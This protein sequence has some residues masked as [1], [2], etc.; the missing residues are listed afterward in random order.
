[1]YKHIGSSARLRW[2]IHRPSFHGNEWFAVDNVT[3]TDFQQTLNSLFANHMFF[4][5]KSRY[6][7]ALGSCSGARS[8]R[9]LLF[10]L[11]SSYRD[12]IHPPTFSWVIFSASS[13]LSMFSATTRRNI[14]GLTGLMMYA[15][16]CRFTE[17]IALSKDGYPVIMI[18]LARGRIS[19]TRANKSV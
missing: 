2:K 5:P 19:W 11:V 17:S 15:S 8:L 3:S 4:R 10:R 16:A 13:C 7:S 6:S 14:S 1:Q 12:S 9:L 18:F